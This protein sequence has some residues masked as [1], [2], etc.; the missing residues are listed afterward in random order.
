MPRPAKWNLEPGVAV[1]KKPKK[2]KLKAFQPREYDEQYLFFR[3]L[4]W[5]EKQHPEVR[6]CFAT[7][8]GVKMGPRIAM[9]A[10]RAGMKNGVSDI[11]FLVPRGEYKGLLIELKARDGGEVSAAQ[12]EF[13]Q[14]QREQGYHG[15]ICRGADEAYNAFLN[16]LE[17]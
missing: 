10:K 5:L 14:F 11:M 13:L 9:I 16:Y 2:L 8:N 15:I 1:K 7:V 6:W 17:G 4:E 3:K 12:L